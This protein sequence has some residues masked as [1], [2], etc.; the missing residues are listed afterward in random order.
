MLYKKLIDHSHGRLS[1]KR[2]AVSDC[3]GHAFLPLSAL[4]TELMVY[5]FLHLAAVV[6]LQPLFHLLASLAKPCGYGL[7]HQLIQ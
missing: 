4:L 1:F 3:K 5:W 2:D 6:L 7:V